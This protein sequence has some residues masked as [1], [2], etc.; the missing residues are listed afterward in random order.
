MSPSVHLWSH[1]LYWLN[2]LPAASHSEPRVWWL[3]VS[4]SSWGQQWGVRIWPHYWW[5][6]SLEC[7]TAQ[8]WTSP[9]SS[10]RSQLWYPYCLRFHLC[11]V[12][13]L[14]RGLSVLELLENSAIKSTKTFP[15]TIVLD[16]Y[17]MMHDFNSMSHFA[18]YPL[19]YKFSIIFF[20]G[21]FISTTIWWD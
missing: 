4:L 9:K 2:S 10:G 16:S 1:T 12:Y 5:Q 6:E 8:W 20:E 19:A 13:I 21:C 3:Q 11:S 18:I 17:L 15:L 7:R 14:P